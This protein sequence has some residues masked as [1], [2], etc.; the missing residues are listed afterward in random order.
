MVGACDAGYSCVYQNTFCW[1]DETTPVPME[2]HPRAVFER[3]FGEEAT[4]T[5]Q[6]AQNRVIAQHPRLGD[7]RDE[8]AAAAASGRPTGDAS[9]TISRPI[10]EVEQRIQRAEA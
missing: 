10:R 9:T 6:A 2:I 7:A 4:P 1:K 8:P 5:E 3:L